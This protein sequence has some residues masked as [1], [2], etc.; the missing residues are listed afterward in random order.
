M[1]PFGK[2][3][4]RFTFIS[5]DSLHRAVSITHYQ[6]C[7]ANVPRFVKLVMFPSSGNLLLLS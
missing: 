6:T 1:F 7:S 5:R 4:S 3:Q 2:K